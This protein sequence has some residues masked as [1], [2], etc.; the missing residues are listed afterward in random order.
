MEARAAL[1]RVLARRGLGLGPAAEARLEQCAD[2]GTLAR[3]LDQ[4]IVAA[5]AEQA[6]D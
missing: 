6:L 5:S 4:A 3:W 1:R 2:L